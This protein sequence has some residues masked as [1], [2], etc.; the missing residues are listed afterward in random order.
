MSTIKKVNVN[1]QEYDLAGSGGGGVL[2]EITHSELVALR[3]SGGLVQGNKYRITDYNAVFNTLR[4]AGH[5]FDIVVEALS[6]SELSEKASAMIHE[7]DVY[8]ENSHLDLWTVYY[9][10]DNDTSRFKEASASGKGF[11]WRLIDEYNNDVCFDFKNALFTL[12]SSDFDFV[13]SD[14]LDFY[15][16]SH[17]ET[18]TPSQSDI[19]DKTIVRSGSVYNNIVKFKLT[20][21][22]K[23]VFGCVKGLFDSISPFLLS[24]NRIE[25]IESVIVFGM[26]ASKFASSKICLGAKVISKK[27]VSN[28]INSVFS[29]SL[30][31]EGT[32]SINNTNIC[33]INKISYEGDI[34]NCFI[35]GGLR[36]PSLK[37]STM[38]NVSVKIIATNNNTLLT[39]S[40]RL[41]SVDVYAKENESGSYDIKIV[42]PFAQ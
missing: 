12:S 22:P 11:I 26:S 41:D 36:K 3:N 33:D 17:L 9:S 5:Q 35:Y 18:G 27:T 29:A 23:L 30:T 42:D 2:I 38:N 19:K 13:T 7:G 25:A 28:I 31:L 16:F 21:S 20:S 14:S 6:S 40:D 32:Y 39:L 1:G 15:L 34:T 8:F 4:S 10:L 24:C 37:C